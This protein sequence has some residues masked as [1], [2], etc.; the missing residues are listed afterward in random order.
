MEFRTSE[1][2]RRYDA[3]VAAAAETVIGLD[4]DGVL[5]PI[6]EDPAAAVIHPDGPDVLADLAASVRAVAVI[7]GRPARQA[8]SL[9]S[10]DAVADSIGESGQLLVLGQYGNERWASRTREFTSPEP[11]PGLAI[12]RDELPGLLVEHDA[13]LAFVEDKGM[14]V[15]VHTRQLPQPQ[16]TFDRLLPALAEAARRHHLGVEPGRMVVEIRPEGMDKGQAVRQVHGELDADG[17]VFAGDDLGDVK[18]FEAVASL[19]EEGHPALLVCSASQEQQALVEL[20]DIVV[21]GPSG[22]LTLL[23]RLAADARAQVG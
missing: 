2:Q 8:V 18:A 16:A 11:P 7:T 5:S 14:A 12:L 1:G 20:S 23:R 15:A 10:L 19:R 17:F 22:V 6:V 9:G 4:F 21:D 13:E 3:V